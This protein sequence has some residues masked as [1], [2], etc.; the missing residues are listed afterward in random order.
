MVVKTEDS[1]AMQ[2]PTFQFSRYHP[3]VFYR[4]LGKKLL[5]LKVY[6]WLHQRFPETLTTISKTTWS[7]SQKHINL[8]CDLVFKS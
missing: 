3:T 7:Y 4:T 6:Y 5:I 1:D 2:L 8:K